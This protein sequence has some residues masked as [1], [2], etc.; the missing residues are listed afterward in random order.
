MQSKMIL[1]E[2]FTTALGIAG[3]VHI[4]MVGAVM[5]EPFTPDTQQQIRLFSCA[6]HIV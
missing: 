2:T 1:T 6:A 5:L 4:F 3:D